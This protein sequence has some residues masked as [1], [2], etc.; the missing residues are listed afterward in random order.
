[1]YSTPFACV[2]SS[3]EGIWKDLALD[4]TWKTMIGVRLE[5]SNTSQTPP[6]W[7]LMAVRK[8][9]VLG[10]ELGRLEGNS[11]CVCMHVYSLFHQ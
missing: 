5:T 1:M 3:A 11:V 10:K 9:T 4:T 6:T 2:Q 8:G 7:I